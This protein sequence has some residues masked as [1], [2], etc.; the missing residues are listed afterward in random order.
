MAAAPAAAAAAPSPAPQAAAPAPPAP[1]PRQDVH[2]IDIELDEDIADGD[3]AD[4]KGE[5]YEY[6]EAIHKRFHDELDD[7]GWLFEI[8][9]SHDFTIPA[10]MAKVVCRKLGAASW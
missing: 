9:R 10:S 1:P 2:C 4:A 8:L 5:F 3:D 6:R 7:E